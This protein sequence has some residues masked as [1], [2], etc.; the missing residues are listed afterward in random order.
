MYWLDHILG[1][2]SDELEWYQ[3]ICRAILVYLVAL[4]YLRVAGMRSISNSSA[5]DVVITITMG[6]ILSRAITGHYP[7]FP[8]IGTALVMALFHRLIAF[9]SFKSR[10]AR[11]LVEGSPVL[12]FRE[13]FFMEKN[14]SLHSIHRTDL[15]RTLREQGVDDYTKVKSIW[16]EV[17][18][19]ISVVRK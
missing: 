7:F 18:G 19:K 4:T 6:G 17:D 9:L 1:L 13:G 3:M 15:D 8:I 5:F 14:L 16:Y 11:K 12:L 2:G 10:A